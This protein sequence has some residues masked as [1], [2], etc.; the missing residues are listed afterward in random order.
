[1]KIGWRTV[2]RDALAVLLL[3]FLGALVGG[4][5]GGEENAGF[6]APS[7]I[8]LMAAGFCVSGCLVKGARFKHL[9]FVAI[10]VWLIGTITSAISAGGAFVLSLG[11]VAQIFA[12]MLLGWLISLAVVR[13]PPSAEPPAP[14]PPA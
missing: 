9:V 8:V 10:G 7:V 5:L 14:P 12:A 1:M 6:Q 11:S 13:P 3:G 2:L 4:A